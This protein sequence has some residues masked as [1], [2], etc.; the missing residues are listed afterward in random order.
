MQT[1]IKYE[2]I[3]IDN[4]EVTFD[5]SQLTENKSLHINATQIAKQ[6]KKTPKDWLRLKETKD[7][8]DIVSREENMPNGELISIKQGGNHQGTWVHSHLAI[9]Y[10][11]WLNP[12]FA[13]KC[14]KKIKELLQGQIQPQENIQPFMMEM[15]K[16]NQETTKA[17]V[18]ISSNMESLFKIAMNTSND[19]NRM[20]ADIRDMKEKG[21][22][23]TIEKQN[24]GL[25]KLLAMAERNINLRKENECLKSR[26]LA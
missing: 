8:I 19:V 25:D 12:E 18:Q 24:I 14:D 23:V 11:R 7:Y 9:V 21:V 13:Y 1:N 6:F 3:E 22:T 2:I 5:L 17:I 26:E 15:I 20:K 16:T 10:L 4:K